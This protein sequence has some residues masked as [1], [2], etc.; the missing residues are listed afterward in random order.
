MQIEPD[1]AETACWYSHTPIAELDDL[2]PAQLV[3]VGRFEDVLRF[4]CS[5]RDGKRD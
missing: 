1:P 2:T 3:L 5:I 4:L